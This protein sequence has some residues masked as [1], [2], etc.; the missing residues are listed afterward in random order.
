MATTTRTVRCRNVRGA[1]LEIEL[2]ERGGFFTPGS[3]LEQDLVVAANKQVFVRK[4]VSPIS[5]S[6]EPWRYDLLDNEIRAGARLGQVFGERYPR[7]L[8]RLA[9]YN[10]DAEEPFVL[11]HHYIG[12]PALEVA[13]RLEEQ[14]RKAFQ[15]GL[16]YALEAT[17][18]AG[19]VHGALTL[20]A[21]RWDGQRVQVVDFERAQRVG[22]RRRRGTSA[23]RAPEQVA[24]TGVVDARD[25]VWGAGQIIRTLY[26][27]E[28]AAGRSADRGGE[29][30]RL[31]A[32]LDPIFHSPPESRPQ[33]S[34]LLAMTRAPQQSLMV[35]D[36]ERGLAPGREQFDQHCADKRRATTLALPRRSRSG[37]RG[38][39][40]FLTVVVIVVVIGMLVLI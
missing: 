14:Q 26:M 4:W 3:L 37:P 30:D 38:L 1:L 9:A 19:V 33:P 11:L 2:T 29:P 24:G 40:P 21:V 27:G 13:N 23:A 25:D 32:L 20:D 31:R 6:H 22:E 5:G 34:D 39:L 12:E 8:A 15:A 7:G 10:M 18:A 17:A 28:P 36:P 16:L 35:V